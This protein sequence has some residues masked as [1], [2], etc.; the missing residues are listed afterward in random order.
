MRRPSSSPES[1]RTARRASLSARRTNSARFR[2]SRTA[3]VATARTTSTPWASETARYRLSTSIARS[4]TSGEIPPLVKVDSPSRSISRSRSRISREPGP[5]RRETT[6]CTLLAPMS[7][8][9]IFMKDLSPDSMSKS[10]TEPRE[11]A[12]TGTEGFVNDLLTDAALQPRR[13]AAADPDD[14]FPS[15]FPRW[16]GRE[17]AHCH[18]RRAAGQV[19]HQ[20]GAL[21]HG[22]HDAHAALHDAHDPR[23]GHEDVRLRD[24]AHDP[25]ALQDG[26]AGDFV[27]EHHPRGPLDRVVGSD[28]LHLPGHEVAQARGGAA[29]RVLLQAQDRLQVAHREDAGEAAVL[30]D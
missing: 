23:E 26:Q 12:L 28:G 16:I 22:Q 21:G 27:V 1:T 8:A 20:V 6:R 9:A 29:D 4:M 5:W 10:G 24:D 3:E 15:P 11:S 25:L 13:R 17:A 30:G 7:I 14:G 19:V 18:P 2:A